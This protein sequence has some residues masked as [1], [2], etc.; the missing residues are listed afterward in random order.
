[1]KFPDF[2]TSCF[3]HKEEILKYIIR[4]KTFKACKSLSQEFYSKTD[5]TS[6]IHAKLQILRQSRD[7]PELLL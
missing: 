3:N 6:K 4:T 7:G 5:N 2:L 1:M